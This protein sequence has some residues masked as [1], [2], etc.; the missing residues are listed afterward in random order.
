MPKDGIFRLASMSK[1]ITAVVVMMLLE[2]GKVRTSDPVWRFIPEFKGAK[3]A[4]AKGG[5][6]P[7]AATGGRGG[8]GGPPVEVDLF[9]ATREITIRDLL[10]HGLGARCGDT[11]GSPASTC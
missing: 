1:P 10:T 9:A 5:V 6:E 7:P 2:E 4:V 11:A 3:V 8:R